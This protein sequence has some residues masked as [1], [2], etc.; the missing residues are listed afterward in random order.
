MA[1]DPAGRLAQTIEACIANDRRIG[2]AGIDKR[3]ERFATV[4]AGLP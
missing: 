3:V 2:C 4:R 1:V